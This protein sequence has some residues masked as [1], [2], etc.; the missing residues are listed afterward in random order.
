MAMVRKTVT[1]PEEIYEEIQKIPADFNKI[2]KEA[3]KEYI[4]KRKRQRL[5][6]LA[7]SLKEW[8]IDGLEYKKAMRKEDIE[9]SKSGENK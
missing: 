1:L 2:V 5:F 7:G 8:N 3:L 4:E 9:T 6:S